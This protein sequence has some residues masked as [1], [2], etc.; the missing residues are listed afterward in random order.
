V[1]RFSLLFG[2]FF[3]VTDDEDEVFGR[4]AAEPI[5]PGLFFEFL[6]PCPCNPCPLLPPPR[7]RARFNTRLI[8]SDVDPIEDDDEDDDRPSP[9]SA[10]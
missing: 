5:L 10:A 1:V 6:R 8:R 9:T 7:S 3:P 2:V 4:E